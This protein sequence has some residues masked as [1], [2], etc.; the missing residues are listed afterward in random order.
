[1][2]LAA[3]AL[4]L[5]GHLS[6]RVSN[7]ANHV[8]V[9][10]MRLDQLKDGIRESWEG[11]YGRD[12]DVAMGLMDWERDVVDR[13]VAPG[14]AVLVIGAGS[15]RDVV[16]LLERGCRVT[17]I[18]PAASS[19]AVLR[20]TLAGRNAKATLVEGFFEDVAIDGR[21]DAVIFSFYSY[22]YIPVSRRRV[23]ALRKA[24]GVLADGGHIVV[25]YP[26]VPQPHP[27]LIQLGR[28][29]GALWRTDW[30]LE[31]GDLV[32][33]HSGGLRGFGHAFQAG[34]LEREAAAADLR[35]TY[36]RHCPDPVAV[37]AAERA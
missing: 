16:P 13:F 20:R 14:T 37:L 5:L 29:A 25:S 23:A 32:S 26:P 17:G 34:E 27:R 36:R 35:I 4:F 3:R 11:F 10:T 7:V 21:F 33:A 9:G 24:A 19:L 6:A 31:P 8:A 2:R 18:E 15:G 30:R 12:E 1:M 28:A 22:S